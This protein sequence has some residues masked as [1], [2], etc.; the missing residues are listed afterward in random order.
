MT[1]MP[2]DP[3]ETVIAARWAEVVG[4]PPSSIE[5]DFFDQG[6]TS[7]QAM[8]LMALL[9]EEFGKDLSA[10][11]IFDRPTIMGLADAV[12]DG[13]GHRR[14]VFTLR[15]D[16]G[17]PMVLGPGLGGGPAFISKLATPEIPRTAI[18][19]LTRG[20]HGEAAPYRHID[21]VSRHFLTALHEAGVRG[22]VHFIGHC[23][24]GLT[25]LRAAADAA[26][27]GLEVKSVLLINTSHATPELT[28]ADMTRIRLQEIRSFAGLP[29]SPTVAAADESTDLD[30]LAAEVFNDV[31]D[32]GAV[33]ESAL[34]AFMVRLDVYVSNWQ[35]AKS[36]V[37][38]PVDVPVHVMYDPD[39]WDAVYGWFDPDAWLVQGYPQLSVESRPGMLYSNIGNPEH[40]AAVG[41][42][43]EK[44]D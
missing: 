28:R 40:V 26:D 30:A 29:E 7:F 42:Y 32:S 31:K 13:G 21:D 15:R 34:D 22:P 24:G 17:I 14:Y 5:D 38:R 36:H 23:M 4:T 8:Q 16:K 27:Y 1:K 44:H 20:T 18:S 10:Q 43:F 9:Q 2:R 37:H 41:A 12:R 35:A 25:V 39:D 19:V 6:Y 3:V 33:S 11:L